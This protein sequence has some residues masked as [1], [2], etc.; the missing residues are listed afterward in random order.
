MFRRSAVDR[1]CI[2]AKPILAAQQ[3]NQWKVV[4]M[5][6]SKSK[7]SE[8]RNT[9]P[10]NKL[11][12]AATTKSLF[13]VSYNAVSDSGEPTQVGPL[14]RWRT[15][16]R[17]D[18]HRMINSITMH[19]QRAIQLGNLTTRRSPVQPLTTLATARS[20][21]S[22]L[23]L[24]ASNCNSRAMDLTTFILHTVPSSRNPFPEDARPR[25]H[26]KQRGATQS[27][28]RVSN[29]VLPDGTAQMP[30][31]RHQIFDAG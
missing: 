3:S 17:N 6:Q 16:N 19:I 12:F 30:G 21:S 29:A 9:L 4:E 20:L 14:V 31:H 28:C 8:Q 2:V 25:R 7:S 27:Q 24:P 5:V 11:C 23:A 22:L 15:H 1:S 13:N 10:M 18:A 26:E